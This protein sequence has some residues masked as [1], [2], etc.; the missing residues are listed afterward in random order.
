MFS[1]VLAYTCSWY[2]LVMH[3]ISL[4]PVVV[5]PFPYLILFESWLCLTKT[6]CSFHLY[7]ILYVIVCSYLYYLFHSSNFGFVYPCISRSLRN[8]LWLF[9]GY[10]FFVCVG[11]PL[12][13]WNSL[14]AAF[15]VSYRFWYA[16]S[17][18]I[19]SKIFSYLL[20]DIFSKWLFIRSV[21]SL[22]EFQ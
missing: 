18:L 16:I 7:F 14:S 1:N 21:F 3:W 11:K 2:F 15:G 17:I 4:V 5:S 19:S 9:I 12:L 13:V 8:I 6:S 10:L 22:H 20:F